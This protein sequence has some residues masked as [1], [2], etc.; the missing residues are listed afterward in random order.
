MPMNA[1]CAAAFVGL[2][3]CGGEDNEDRLRPATA[4]ECPNGGTVLERDRGANDIVCEGDVEESEDE[5]NATCD[6]VQ[7]QVAAALERDVRRA[8]VGPDTVACGPA[9]V[10]S[11]AVEFGEALTTMEGQQDL[12]ADYR[13]ACEVVAAACQQ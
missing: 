10:E 8:F 5:P 7:E 11:G 1:R 3:G 2:C 6:D 13:N 12:V 4:E 9:G